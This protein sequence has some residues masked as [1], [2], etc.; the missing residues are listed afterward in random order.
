MLWI[1]G[2]H[3]FSFPRP[4]LVMGVVN[5]TPDSFSDGGRYFSVDAATAHGLELAGQ[6]ADLLDVGGESTRPDAQPVPQDEE[7]RRVLPVIERL[8]AQTAIPIS[9]DTQKPE[10]AAAALAAGASVVNDVAAN[11]EDDAMWRLVADTGAGY[12]CTHMQ[13]T[14]QTM[15]I[16]PHYDDVVAEVGEFFA[17]RLAR[18]TRAGVRPEQ[19]A[20][21]VGVGFG[22]TLE[23]NLD[24]L[25]GLASYRRFGRP[26]VLG[27]SRKSFL[28]RLLGAEIHARLPGSLACACWG[29]LSGAQVFRTHDAAETRQ[30]VRTIEAIAARPVS[31]R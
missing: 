18:L 12:V 24:L 29:V 23:H 27:A 26:L 8:A 21:D 9:I 17:G 28:G 3:S 13:G 30:A 6:G 4:A 11:R 31:G 10:V 2:R 5:V 19:V 15:Q 7:R 22:K 14:P 16:E 20:L 1:C 25:A